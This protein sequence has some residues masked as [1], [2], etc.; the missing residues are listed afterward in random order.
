MSGESKHDAVFTRPVYDPIWDGYGLFT[1]W[2]FTA[3][4]GHITF[5]DP[6]ALAQR[7]KSAGFDWIACQTGQHDTEI[8]TEI[9]KAGLKYVCWG[10]CPLNPPVKPDAVI[11][12]VENVDQYNKALAQLDSLPTPRACVTTFGNSDTPDLVAPLNAACDLAI[13]ECYIEDDPIHADVDRMLWQA[14]QYGWSAAVPIIGLYGDAKLA[15]YKS[16][17]LSKGF[18]VWVAE[19]L[20]DDQ[21]TAVS[22]G[23]REASARR[24]A[25]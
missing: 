18:S 4:G 10:I 5:P 6:T 1:A 24:L 7:A 20:D 21:W 12:Q 23:I 22:E 11:V 16:L 25:G 15:D 3:T 17:D 9:R 14:G 2:G 19:E 13:V 8:A